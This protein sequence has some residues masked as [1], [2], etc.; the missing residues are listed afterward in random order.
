[1]KWSDLMWQ[2]TF[3]GAQQARLSFGNEYE[4]S[5]IT[6]LNEPDLFELAIFVGERFVK[7]FGIH[8]ELDDDSDDVLRFQTREEVIGVIRKLESITGEVPLNVYN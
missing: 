7:I 2:D 3:V 1:M 8:P 5:I 4:L 6:E